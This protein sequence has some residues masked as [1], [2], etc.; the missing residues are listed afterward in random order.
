[1]F[2]PATHD[3]IK[4]MAEVIPNVFKWSDTYPDV[5]NGSEMDGLAQSLQFTI[6]GCIAPSVGSSSKAR[7]VDLR[8]QAAQ[9]D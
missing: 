7:I 1:V 9:K 4:G 5:L 3:D 8:N 2:D 6:D